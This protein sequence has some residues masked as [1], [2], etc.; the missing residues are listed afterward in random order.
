MTLIKPRKRK[1]HLLCR[2]QFA[3]LPFLLTS[4][5]GIITR[6][7][8]FRLEI[9]LRGFIPSENFA[10]KLFFTLADIK[11]FKLGF[12][13][14]LVGEKPLWFWSVFGLRGLWIWFGLCWCTGWIPIGLS[15]LL[16]LSVFI[17]TG[18]MMVK[19]RII[20]NMLTEFLIIDEEMLVTKSL[21][22]YTN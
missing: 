21:N 22:S 6:F 10:V 3:I 7:I 4:N 12:V 18:A 19:L 1:H 14:D 17:F 5:L 15:S 11:P 13:S 8:V 9:F 2:I 16:P 20:N